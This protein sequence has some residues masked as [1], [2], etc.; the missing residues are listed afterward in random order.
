[1]N[2]GKSSD[3]FDSLNQQFEN[4]NIKINQLNNLLMQCEEINQ[5]V[6][7]RSSSITEDLNQLRE[8]FLSFFGANSPSTI[9][10]K[11]IQQITINEAKIEEIFVCRSELTRIHAELKKKYAS[12]NA[13]NMSQ[14][15]LLEM[16]KLEKKVAVVLSN[17]T[18]LKCQ[19]LQPLI[20]GLQAFNKPDLVIEVENEIND[21]S[22]E[23]INHLVQEIKAEIRAIKQH[24]ANQKALIIADLADA[25]YKH[26]K[27]DETTLK[28]QF[29][30]CT[31]QIQTLLVLPF[32]DKQKQKIEAA[33]LKVQELKRDYTTVLKNFENVLHQASENFSQVNLEKKCKQLHLELLVINYSFQESLAD[34]ST[35]KLTAFKAD[36]NQLNISVESTGHLISQMIQENVNVMQDLQNATQKLAEF[37]NLHP[38]NRATSFIGDISD[39]FVI[40][41]SSS[42]QPVFNWSHTMWGDQLIHPEGK[43]QFKEHL[44][45]GFKNTIDKL[46]QTRSELA[47]RIQSL[48]VEENA[49]E[50]Q[51]LTQDL[52]QVNRVFYHTFLTRIT[53]IVGNKE[54]TLKKYSET[55]SEHEKV[56]LRSEINLLNTKFEH[57]YEKYA[58]I[59][60]SSHS[61]LKAAFSHTFNT[62]KSIVSLGFINSQLLSPEHLRREKQYADLGYNMLEDVKAWMHTLQ[63]KENETVVE[64]L[65]REIADFIRWSDSDPQAA[66]SLARDMSLT[67]AIIGGKSYMDQFTQT[68]RVKAYGAALQN[69]WNPFPTQDFVPTEAS[70]KYYSLSQLF[71][72]APVLTAVAKSLASNDYSSPLGAASKTLIEGIKSYSVQQAGDFIPHEYAAAALQA[73][74]ILRGESF[75]TI[76]EEQRNLE[77]VR[78]SGMAAKFVSAPKE[79]VARLKLQ[80]KI[81]SKTVRN[82]TGWEKVGRVSLQ[83]LLPAAAVVVT[84]AAI[85]ACIL[86]GP[87]TWIAALSVGITSLS[88][89][90]M[91]A[92]KVDQWF[93][94]IFSTNKQIV[95]EMNQLARLKAEQ[96]LRH[97]IQ[98]QRQKFVE[99]LEQ[100]QV[101]PKFEIKA[102]DLEADQAAIYAEARKQLKAKFLDELTKKWKN[103]P[104]H[105]AVAS[106]KCYKEVV[107]DTMQLA[108]KKM[109]ETEEFN[110]L[111]NQ[112]E[113]CN[114]LSHEIAHAVKEE[115]LHA[116]IEEIFMR[117]I[118]DTNI[119][120][121]AVEKNIQELRT[122]MERDLKRQFPD[123]VQRNEIK[124]ELNSL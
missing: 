25:H 16:L 61:L 27:I 88:F 120:I 97:A 43:T 80:M 5:T 67:C 99:D 48:T 115:W 28:L 34:L 13:D 119:S 95:K 103:S 84:G 47:T 94:T 106:V 98:E 118:L 55:L 72:C 53:D 20:S 2:I 36:V 109:S 81:W 3:F 29:K 110:A 66:M 124:E 123:Q 12:K 102:M 114:A 58:A 92:K 38:E 83:V 111:F 104:H 105:D 107:L 112:K 4:H 122:Q 100:N 76:L 21:S 1:M 22:A 24:D 7:D 63:V 69:G 117:R 31:T 32:S 41:S 51:A 52:N 45:I 56:I 101:I 89:S 50:I 57:Y 33:F 68:M 82:S 17:F 30:N 40:D 78:L 42:F 10:D 6:L 23:D 93:N 116:K 75:Q 96:A 14:K 73:L 35:I 60:V 87:I 15:E 91:L 77:L 62:L 86:G 71:R 90:V 113:I 65:K 70:L 108:I 85:T 37:K 49:D 74:N 59:P 44:G 54:R 46:K 39:L 9:S 121:E 64:V 18:A 79:F 26:V 8:G 11:T 19:L